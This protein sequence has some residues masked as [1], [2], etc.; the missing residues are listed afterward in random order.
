MEVY[1]FLFK[2][3]YMYKLYLQLKLQHKRNKD[4]ETFDN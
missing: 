4:P 1:Y 2:D 3:W